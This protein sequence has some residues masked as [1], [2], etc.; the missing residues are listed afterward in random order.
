MTTVLGPLR[1]ER[2]Y[3]RCGTGFHPRDRTLGIEGA[4]LSPGVVRMTGLAAARASFADRPTWASQNGVT[5]SRAQPGPSTSARAK[6]RD[7]LSGRLLER[8]V[9]RLAHRLGL[10]TGELA[11]HAGTPA[12]DVSIRRDRGAQ[13]AARPGA[14]LDG[15]LRVGRRTDQPHSR[16]VRPAHDA[17]AGLPAFVDGPELD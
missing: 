7:D 3:Y 4:S 11:H 16:K 9:E 8:L 12:G 6:A 13:G 17:D 15:G 14:N 10:E 2:A 5:A 1:L